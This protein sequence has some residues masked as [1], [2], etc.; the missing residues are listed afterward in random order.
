MVASLP[1]TETHEATFV[2]AARPKALLYGVIGVVLVESAAVHALIFR[3]YP[4]GSLVLLLF[5][6]ATIWYLMR[7]A[8]APSTVRIADGALDIRSGNSMRLRVPLAHVSEVIEPEWRQIPESGADGY[9]SIAAGDDPNVLLRFAP[10]ARVELAL[11]MRKT[12]TTLGLRLGAPRD[13]TAELKA[14]LG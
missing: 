14:R 13:L 12:V 11:G 8:R 7:E 9:L 4:L 10:A 3:R 1:P 5:N 2:L 6:L